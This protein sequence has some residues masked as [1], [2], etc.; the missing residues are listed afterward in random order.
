MDRAATLRALS[1]ELGRQQ[2]SARNISLT[3]FAA[4]WTLSL[5]TMAVATLDISPNSDKSIEIVASMLGSIVVNAHWQR[6][7]DPS[8]GVMV[9]GAIGYT[10]RS[11]LVRIQSTLNSAR[12]IPG[13][14]RLVALP[15]IQSLRNPT[16]QQVN[17]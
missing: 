10:S 4:A 8:P 5:E 14:L 16:F 1:Q 7:T 2:M 9:S 11:P 13:V 17:E 12:Y 6:H 15:F 3:T